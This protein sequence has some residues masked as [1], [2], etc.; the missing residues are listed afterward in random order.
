[1]KA[2][3]ITLTPYRLNVDML[4]NIIISSLCISTIICIIC[5][6]TLSMQSACTDP[7]PPKTQCKKKK[8]FVKV[9]VK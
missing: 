3:H 1:M 8:I 6:C 2:S 7:T 5:M 9:K 4:C